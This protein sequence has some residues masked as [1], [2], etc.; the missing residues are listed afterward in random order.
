MSKHTTTK[1][2]AVASAILSSDW[3]EGGTVSVHLPADA[4]P[5]LLDARGW[6]FHPN[7]QW[8]SPDRTIRS[9]YADEAL[10]FALLAEVNQ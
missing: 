9:W 6:T 8:V 3:D 1:G 5:A 2:L 4:A 7:G 10:Q